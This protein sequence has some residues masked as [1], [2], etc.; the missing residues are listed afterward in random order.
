LF[1]FPSFILWVPLPCFRF[2]YPPALV[3]FHEASISC[4]EPGSWDIIRYHKIFLDLY[5]FR[6]PSSVIATL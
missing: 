5:R 4:W 1:I 2:C 6:Y 3:C